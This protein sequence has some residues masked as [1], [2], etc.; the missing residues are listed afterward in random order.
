MFS[1]IE[2]KTTKLLSVTE[3]TTDEL[4]DAFLF[5]REQIEIISFSEF[6]NKLSEVQ[7]SN[8]ND[9]PYIALALKRRCP[10]FSGD[11]QLKQ[12]SKVP[13]YSPRELLDI[14]ARE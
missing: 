3:L 10:V 5:I 1:E 12:Q 13:V 9:A 6:S 4:Q 8:M 14:L 2:K 11:K 7:K